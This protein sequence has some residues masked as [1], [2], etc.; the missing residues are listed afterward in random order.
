MSRSAVDW[1]APPRLNP[2]HYVSAEIYAN[3]DLFREEQEKIFKKVWLIACHES[4][5]PNQ[6]DYRTYSHPGGTELFVIRGSDDKIRAFYNICPHRGTTLLYDPAGNAKHITCIF[7]QWSFNDRG[8]CTNITREQ[9][10]YGK[11]VSKKDMGLREVRT[12][13][14]LGGFIWVNLDDKCRSLKE[15]LGGVLNAL[16]K[17]LSA[18]PLEVFTY[19]RSIVHTNYKLWHDT[20]SELYHDFVH[21]HNR[22]T[23]MMQQGYWD[24]KIRCYPNGHCALDSMTVRYDAYEGFRAQRKLGWPKAPDN[25]HIVC[26]IFPGITFNLRSPVFRLDTMIP[27]GANKVMIEFR[28]AGLKSDTPEVRAQRVRDYNGIWGPFG[29]NLHEDLLAVTLQGRAMHEGTDAK[30]VLHAREEGLGPQDEQGM[31]HFYV[32]W[33]KRMGRQASDPYGRRKLQSVAA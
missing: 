4:E 18:E 1:N 29:R 10:A 32:E 30:Y 6:Y 7:H 11:K 24:R 20:N 28:G 3:E 15:H 21:Y 26:D 27:L 33:S 2:A 22:V 17:P 14:G 25:C 16:E 19:H 8:A 9:P 12:E 5:V 13:A 23:A 31:R